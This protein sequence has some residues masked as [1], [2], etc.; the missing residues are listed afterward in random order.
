M[1]AM[2]SGCS[3]VIKEAWQSRGDVNPI[4]NLKVK[5]EACTGD[6]L[7]W[8][9]QH[10]GNIQAQIRE[11][12]QKLKG[13]GDPK[14]RKEIMKSIRELRRKEEVL[15]WQRSRINFLKYGDSNSKW[16]HLKA[17][18]RKRHNRITKLRD[19]DGI[20]RESE[21]EL[22]KVVVDYFMDLFSSSHPADFE[23]VLDKVE[24]RVTAEMNRE[25]G[26][27]YTG[28]EVAEALKQMHP[29]KAPGP[30]GM[31]PFFFQNYWNIVG[32]AVID[33]VLAI[34]NGASIPSFLN[35]TNVVLIPKN[36]SP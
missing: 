25:L 22:Q 21:D 27:P 2:D 13:M 6:L 3:E 24:P 28:E 9:K 4:L 36:N 5:T 1:W 15:W 12:E 29:S 8:N 19:N 34:L 17:S 10:F 16:F 26:K 14:T 7:K 35:H 30:D 32:P 18:E 11:A 20:W 31:N 33:C 23:G